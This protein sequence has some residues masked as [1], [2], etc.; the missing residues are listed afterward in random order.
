VHVDFGTINGGSDYYPIVRGKSVAATYGYTTQVELGMLRSG[1][2]AWGQG[3][4]LVGSGEGSTPQAIY[5]FDINGNV[6]IPGEMSFTDYTIRCD[7][8]FKKE[9]TPIADP[10]K[11]LP[12][13]HGYT[14]I[15]QNDESDSGLVSNEWEWLPGATRRKPL[16]DKHGKVV[17]GEDYLS[18]RL[19]GPVGYLLE[20]IKAQQVL[21]ERQ[22]VQITRLEKML[23]IEESDS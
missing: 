17:E 6:T 16:T 21:I 19:K 10:L 4:L 2:A 22:G 20:C 14:F 9:L 12:D 3:I 8:K 23:G 5:S 11:K 13:L 1:G 15:N 7:V 18:L